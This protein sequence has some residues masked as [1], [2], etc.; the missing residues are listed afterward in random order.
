MANWYE[1]SFQ[2][3]NCVS[4]MQAEYLQD[5]IDRAHRRFLTSV[6]TL[7]RVRKLAVPILQVNLANNQ[8]INTSATPK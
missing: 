7:A 8:Q 6:E 4:I 2:R 3:T 1:E 5:R